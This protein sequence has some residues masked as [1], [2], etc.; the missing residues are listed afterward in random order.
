LSIQLPADTADHVFV[1]VSRSILVASEVNYAVH[2]GSFGTGQAMAY[3]A[4]GPAGRPLDVKVLGDPLGEIHASISL[5]A[6]EQTVEHFL[7]GPSPPLLRSFPHP[8]VL[9]ESTAPITSVPNLPCALNGILDAPDDKDVFRI[10]VKKGDRYR[11]R[12]YSAALGSPLDPSLRITPATGDKPEIE[13][14]DADALLADRDIHGPNIRSRGGLKD[15]FDPSVIFEPKMDG[16]Y[17]IELR[18]TNGFG[19]VTGALPHRDRDAAGHRL[20]LAPQRRV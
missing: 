3:P 2:I 12:V 19:S 13:T 8:N 4:G 16:D 11:V 15:V 10:S 17:L 7:D 9:E 18:D 1:E 6:E 5:P 20:R 14:D